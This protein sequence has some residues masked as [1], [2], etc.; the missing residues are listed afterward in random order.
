MDTHLSTVKANGCL[1]LL[2]LPFTLTALTFGLCWYCANVI[3][4]KNGCAVNFNFLSS[5]LYPF[6]KK[7]KV[8]YTKPR[9]FGIQF[10]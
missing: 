3:H 1:T 7:V 2:I 10:S 8:N 9:L 6:V 5:E 4:F